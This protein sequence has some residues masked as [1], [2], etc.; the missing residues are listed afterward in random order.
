MSELMFFNILFAVLFSFL[1]AAI[2][3]LTNAYYG[4]LDN[5]FRNCA[6]TFFVAFISYFVF[7]DIPA[8]TVVYTDDN[9]KR[10]VIFTDE[11]ALLEDGSIHFVKYDGMCVTKKAGEFKLESNK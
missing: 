3:G 6:I 8:Y 5:E 2:A 1:A 9:M 10:H 11:V 4:D 7:V